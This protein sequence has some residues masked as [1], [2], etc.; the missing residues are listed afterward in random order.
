MYGSRIPAINRAYE[1]GY[2]DI[3]CLIMNS[4]PSKVK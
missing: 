4:I 2:F 1:Y 3:L